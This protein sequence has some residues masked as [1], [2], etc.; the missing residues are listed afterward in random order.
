MLFF[1]WPTAVIPAFASF[2]FSPFFTFLFLCKSLRSLPPDIVVPICL[3][4][5]SSAYLSSHL[6]FES[7][8]RPSLRHFSLFC[9]S[10]DSSCR[11]SSPVT[12]LL[13]RMIVH[14]SVTLPRCLFVYY[15]LLFSFCFRLRLFIYLNVIV[16]RYLVR[17]VPKPERH[18]FDSH[19]IA[20]DALC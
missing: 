20:L 17:V 11:S 12:C 3:S 4:N 13:L 10:E 6:R 14:L 8:V 1:L 19:C 9:V 7:C 2:F 5:L 16:P 18:S 15:F